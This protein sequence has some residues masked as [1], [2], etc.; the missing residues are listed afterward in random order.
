MTGMNLVKY[1]NTMEYAVILTGGKQ[2]KVSSGL[3]LQVEN[4]GVESGEYSFDKVLLHVSEGDVF[5]GK[6]YI[7]GMTVKAKI[8]G[9]AKGDKVRVSKF[10]GKSRYRKTIGFRKKLTM[11]EV[12]S[13]DKAS[14]SAP[15]KSSKEV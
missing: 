5:I 10:K 7:E 14:K 12:I 11:V 2:L 6:P 15:K 1:H 8:L 3:K 9:L 4:L 13:F